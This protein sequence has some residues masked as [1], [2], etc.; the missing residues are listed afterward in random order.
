MDEEDL[1][2]DFLDFC[3]EHMIS[4]KEFPGI[5]AVCMKLAYRMCAFYPALMGELKRTIEGMDMTFYTPAVKGLRS[6]ILKGKPIDKWMKK[7]KG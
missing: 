1:R 6:K 2:T 4:V 5:Q 3:L 7:K